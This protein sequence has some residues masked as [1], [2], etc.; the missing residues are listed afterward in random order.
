M[1]KRRSH[2]RCRAPRTVKR[3]FRPLCYR[4]A[5]GTFAAGTEKRPRI[6]AGR[7]PLT[8]QTVLRNP[9]RPAYLTP[10][11]TMTA[12]AP[13]AATE[14]T[15]ASARHALIDVRLT[16]VE[17]VARDTNIYTLRRP[18]GGKLPGYKPGAHIDLHLPNGL[19]RQYSLLN[20][21]ADPDHYVVA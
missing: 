18:D 19:V 7:T 11:N 21:S 17:T 13:A 12:P 20:P 3:H 15:A 6:Q 4:P 14:T 9:H 16:E 10:M 5:P 1:S 8:P 2:R